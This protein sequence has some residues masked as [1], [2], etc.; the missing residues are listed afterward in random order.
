MQASGDD[1][2]AYS[3]DSDNHGSFAF[4]VH[5][6]PLV[7]ISQSGDLAIG[8]VAN[9]SQSSDVLIRSAFRQRCVRASR[10]W[11]RRRS[12]GGGAAVTH[13]CLA[14]AALPRPGFSPAERTV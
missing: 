2:G 5:H 12:S 4:S 10:C 9:L 1:A 14:S 6:G 3:L 7:R 8:Q 11:R 13:D